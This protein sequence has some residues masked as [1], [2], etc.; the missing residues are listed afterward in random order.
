[1]AD[2]GLTDAGFVKPSSAQ[3]RDFIV[4]LWRSKF[5]ENAQTASDSPDGL[6]IDW[7][8]RAAS[9]FWD[10][11]EDTYNASFLQTSRG[12]ALRMIT[13]VI[14]KFDLEPTPSTVEAVLYGTGLV[15]VTSGSLVGTGET[16]FSVD[17]DATIGSTDG[18]Y[19]VRLTAVADGTTYQITV[20][21]TNL[22]T[23]SNPSSTLD[24]VRATLIGILNGS[25]E[26]VVATAGGSDPSGNALIVV[27]HDSGGAFTA[28]STTTL[29]GPSSI[30]DFPAIRQTCTNTIDG[31][32]PAV[33]GT[34]VA[35]GNT[36]SGWEGVT[37]TA[38]ATLGRDQEE[39]LE[40]R[41]RVRELLHESGVSTP[42][43]M[44]DRVASPIR[45]PGVEAVRVDE[46]VTLVTDLDGRPGKSFEVTA[47]GGEDEDVAQAIWDSKPL[48]IETFGSTSAVAV[49]VLGQSQ[50]VNFSRTVE[51]FVHMDVTVVPGERYPSSGDPLVAIR[52]AIAA[53]GPANLGQGDDVYREELE[54]VATS[55]IPGISSLTITT[56]TTAAPLDPPTLTASDIAVA[57]DEIAR[58][59]ASRINVHL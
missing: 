2:F 22:G 55:T 4:A 18:I 36:I 8:T 6:F 52:D 29:T 43:A 24:S 13:E 35:V 33:A 40:F 56:D 25:A 45:V 31:E 19:V 37:N 57:D 27:E 15:V 32:E 53:W 16:T 17:D 21:G 20:N 38:D 41:S 59:A 58:F 42:D 3:A 51:L 28:F 11:A 50:T 47:L 5:G 1:M 39:D 30:D 7:L 46:N 54:G 14:S 48:G 49:D 26:P 10:A 44:H 12:R 23:T 34:L 9:W